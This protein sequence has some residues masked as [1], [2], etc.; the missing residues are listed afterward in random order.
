MTKIFMLVVLT[1]C[2]QINYSYFTYASNFISGNKIEIDK[3]Y[4]DSMPYSFIKVSYGR[5]NQAVFVLSAIDNGVYKWIGSNFEEIHTFNGIIIKTVGINP[6]IELTFA[7][8]IPENL[9]NDSIIN[10]KLSI[11]EP[12]LIYNDISLVKDQSLE[13]TLYFKRISKSLGWKSKDKYVYKNNK[14]SYSEQK[15]SPLKPKVKIEFFYK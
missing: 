1:G 5:A 14:I 11:D 4:I 2:S 10:F 13:S 15:I 8:D 9:F 6:A 3:N 7:D 12:K